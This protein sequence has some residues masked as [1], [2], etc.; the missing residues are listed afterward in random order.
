LAPNF[1]SGVNFAVAGATLLP[2]FVPFA[3]DVQV[4]QFI[5]FKKRSLELLSLGTYARSLLLKL[6]I[7]NR[8]LLLTQLFLIL[9]FKK[10]EI[11]FPIFFFGAKNITQVREIHLVKMVSVVQFI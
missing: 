5:R 4:R 3:L 2:Q 8:F 7:T 10:L 1:T 6:H 11:F 9:P